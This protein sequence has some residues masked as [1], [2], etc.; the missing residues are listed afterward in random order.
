M[1]AHQLGGDRQAEGRPADHAAAAV[2][3]P[4]CAG[5]PATE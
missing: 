1:G 4:A 5:R 3:G 2:A